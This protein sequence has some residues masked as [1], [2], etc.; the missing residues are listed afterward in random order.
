MPACE[1]CPGPSEQKP[2]RSSPS[3]NGACKGIEELGQNRLLKGL[4]PV[5]RFHVHLP[6]GRTLWA[7]QENPI[8][9]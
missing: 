6:G 5:Y 8:E 2:V 4:A 7:S 3:R 1:S 9:I